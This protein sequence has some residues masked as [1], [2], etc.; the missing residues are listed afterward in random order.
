MHRAGCP[1]PQTRIHQSAPKILKEKKKGQKGLTVGEMGEKRENY[2]KYMY[3]FYFILQDDEVTYHNLY[4]HAFQVYGRK[5]I[6][7]LFC[8]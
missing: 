2:Q 6:L 5:L 1:L 8:I 3:Q 7:M 4:V